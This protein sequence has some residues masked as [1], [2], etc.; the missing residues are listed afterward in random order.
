MAKAKKEVRSRRVEFNLRE[1]IASMNAKFGEGTIALASEAKNMKIVFCPS[2]C[3]A[4]DY[5]TGG[6]FPQN[7]ISQ[8]VEPYSAGKTTLVLLSIVEFQRKF[9]DGIAVFVDV[10]IALDLDY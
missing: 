9:A 6:G 1:F 2:G 10:E 4:I 7:R 5:V 8:I 3:H